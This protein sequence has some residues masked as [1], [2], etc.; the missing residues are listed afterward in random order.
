MVGG[1]VVARA[2]GGGGGTGGGVAGA[3]NFSLMPD[4]SCEFGETEGRDGSEG[5]AC[6]IRG[7]NTDEDTRFKN[8]IFL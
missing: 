8:C 4:M 5:G 6:L 2:R 3:G 7:A 1:G